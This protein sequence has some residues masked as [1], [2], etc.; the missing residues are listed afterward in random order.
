MTRSFGFSVQPPV[1]V[2]EARSQGRWI[3]RRLERPL[4]FGE[5]A[6][7]LAV[8][9]GEPFHV[10][11]VQGRDIPGVHIVGSGPGVVISGGQHANETSGV[12]GALRAAAVLKARGAHFRADPAGQ[13]RD[14]Y[15]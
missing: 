6:Q 4:T 14:G 10:T 5:I 3:W 15:A 8:L 11:S 1:M 7:A 9:G 12:V 2:A 13:S